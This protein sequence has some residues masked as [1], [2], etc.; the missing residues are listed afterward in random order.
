M[1]TDTT[2]QA[3]L[4][5]AEEGEQVDGYRPVC[6]LAVGGAV[7]GL[8][9]ATSYVH[10]FFWTLAV[11]GVLVSAAALRRIASA[12]GLVGR[13]AAWAGLLL[14]LV[15]GSSAIAHAA[16]KPVR[17]RGEAR[18]FAADWFAALQQGQFAAAHQM[19]I[20][21]WRRLQPDRPVEWLYGERQVLKDDL[22][23]YLSQEPMRSLAALGERAGVRFVRN[24]RF[25]VTLD[26][27]T[28][29][30]IYEIATEGSGALETRL[31]KIELRARQNLLTK[32]WGWEIRKAAW[33]QPPPADWS[34]GQGSDGQRSQG[35]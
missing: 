15:F 27:Y 11:T 31:V 34:D 29:E 28:V 25:K 10:P 17:I 1:T 35:S 8:F 20:V 7:L 33:L 12:P 4:T 14:S 32:Q 19:T 26:D 23:K 18:E 9:S 3:Q 22:D 24:E 16:L 21:H 30:D 6:G 13:R 2:H 5:T